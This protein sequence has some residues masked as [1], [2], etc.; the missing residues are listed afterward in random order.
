MFGKKWRLWRANRLLD[1]AIR[2]NM[3][4]A[5]KLRTGKFVYLGVNPR[6]GLPRLR[7]KRR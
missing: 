2:A 1:Q 3:R 5:K 6:S 4:A 7:R